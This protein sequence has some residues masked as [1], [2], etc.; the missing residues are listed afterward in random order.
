MKYLIYVSSATSLFTAE[1]LKNLLLKSREN[2]HKAGITGL[3]LFSEGNFIQVIEGNAEAI[4]RL[5]AKIKSDVRHDG[6][7]ILNEGVTSERNFPEWTMG[8]KQISR[9]DFSS[10]PGS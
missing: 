3:L 1:D 9:D 4:D 5:Y 2:N 6:F 7:L 10:R 8:F